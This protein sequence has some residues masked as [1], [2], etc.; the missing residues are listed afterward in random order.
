M[1]RPYLLEFF[2]SFFFFWKQA[3]DNE[4]LA[5]I[6]GL[7]KENIEVLGGRTSEEGCCLFVSQ[8]Y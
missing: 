4:V 3:E 8:L 5:G 7:V 1:W 2:I 6:S